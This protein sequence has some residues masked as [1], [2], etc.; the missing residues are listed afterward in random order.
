[1]N[2]TAAT[3][4]FRDEC[5]IYYSVK[6]KSWIAHSLCTDQLG[7]GDC[8]V[9]AI[10]DLLIGTKNLLELKRKDPEIEIFC[11]APKE[12]LNRRKKAKPLPPVLWEVA[13]ERFSK[14]LQY[15]VHFDVPQNTQFTYQFQEPQFA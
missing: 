10:I 11:K 2:Q 5:L 4:S 12:I 7:Y 14:K 13:V 3:S 6:D 15:P 1:M 8:V 9:N